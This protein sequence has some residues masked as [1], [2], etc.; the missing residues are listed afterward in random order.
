MKKEETTITLANGGMHNQK[1]YVKMKA[2]LNNSTYISP[3]L[4]HLVFMGTEQSNDYK[5]AMKAL[6]LELRRKNID[7]Q[8]K[9]CLEVDPA[10]GLHFHVFILVESKHRSPCSILNHN[11]QHWLNVMMQKRGLTY[12]ISPP[13]NPMHLSRLGKKRNYATLAGEKLADCL[14]WISYLVK[15]RS[16]LDSMT[17]I[18]FGSRPT[19]SVLG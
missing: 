18:Y 11:S 12:H 7:C 15:S 19:R 17:H 14:I 13:E 5:A 4:Y 16:K 6:C 2:M 3:R 8:W 10:K 9:G 1:A